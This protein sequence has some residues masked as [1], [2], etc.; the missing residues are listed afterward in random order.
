VVQIANGSGVE[1]VGTVEGGAATGKVT[2]I[3]EYIY[4]GQ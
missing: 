1:L 4:R 3:A 2:V